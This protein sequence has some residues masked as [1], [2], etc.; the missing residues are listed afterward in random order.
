MNISWSLLLGWSWFETR[1]PSLLLGTIQVCLDQI[2]IVRKG[3]MNS[4]QQMMLIF[5]GYVI[6]LFLSQQ[7]FF[8]QTIAF[9]L[10]I[11]HSINIEL[12]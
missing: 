11:K 6:Q 7:L 5:L 4:N 9:F 2:G 10:I 8:Y 1:Q 3:I 12:V